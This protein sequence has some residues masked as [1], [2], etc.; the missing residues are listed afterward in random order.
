MCGCREAPFEGL[1]RLRSDSGVIQSVPFP[2]CSG[3]EAVLED[4]RLWRADS[5]CFLH[6]EASAVVSRHLVY[7]ILGDKV[8]VVL[9]DDLSFPSNLADMSIRWNTGK[10]SSGNLIEE[11][12]SV[13]FAS[14]M[15]W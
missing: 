2:D 15:Q 10:L 9:G 13:V 14:L 3:E 7:N 12:E 4:H 1:D 11:G 5:L 6:S 8:S